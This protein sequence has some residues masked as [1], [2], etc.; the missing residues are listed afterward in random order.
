YVGQT[1]LRPLIQNGFDGSLA[2]ALKQKQP[3]G[4]GVIARIPGIIPPCA[5]NYFALQIK[6]D[7]QRPIHPR[8]G[9]QP[10]N[11]PEISG[12]VAKSVPGTG[13]PPGF[14]LGDLSPIVDGTIEIEGNR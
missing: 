2:G 12:Q 6:L 1:S 10:E 14:H 9:I 3:A 13:N 4:N 5:G 7:V 11:T 8:I